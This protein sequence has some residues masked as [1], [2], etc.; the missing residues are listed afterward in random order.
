MFG[1]D[2]KDISNKDVLTFN[3]SSFAEKFMNK[4]GYE[5]AERVKI[6]ETKTTTTDSGENGK[7]IKETSFDLIEKNKAITYATPD[8]L[9]AKS[10]MSKKTDGDIY[11]NFIE[12]ETVRYN[13]IKPAGQ[14]SY[15]NAYFEEQRTGNNVNSSINVVGLIFDLLKLK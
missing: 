1:K 14:S 9:N 2:L 12:F 5:K 15:K 4:H 6:E 10:D 3:G 11:K 8:K 7:I 13:L